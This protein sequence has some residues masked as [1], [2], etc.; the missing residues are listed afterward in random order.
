VSDDLVAFL[1]AR[2]DEDERRARA[3]LPRWDDDAMEWQDLGDEVYAHARWHDPA[4]VLREVQ[5]DRAILAEYTA[6]RTLQ[7]LTGVEKDGYR[8]WVLRICVAVYSDHEGY[9]EEWK[10]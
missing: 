1:R 6:V 8:D 5:A 3:A 7:G 10:P 2:L 9:R 4:R